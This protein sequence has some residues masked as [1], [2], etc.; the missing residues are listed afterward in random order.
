MHHKRLMMSSNI[1]LGEHDPPLVL[2][3]ERDGEASNRQVHHFKRIM[4]ARTSQAKPTKSTM[5]NAV[6]SVVAAML[7]NREC[8]TLFISLPILLQS[9]H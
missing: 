3:R 9:V 4:S 2:R 1:A 5:K 7:K 8:G 6:P